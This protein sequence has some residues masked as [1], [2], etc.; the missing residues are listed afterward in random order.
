MA[1]LV[2]ADEHVA[3]ARQMEEQDI[4]GPVILINKF[5]VDPK[6]VDKFMKTWT[7]DATF[8]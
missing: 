8:M 1:N 2:E 3:F 7:D 6:D 5:T 4:S